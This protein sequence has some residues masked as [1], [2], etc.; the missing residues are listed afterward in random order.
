MKKVLLITGVVLLVVGVILFSVGY[1]VSATGSNNLTSDSGAPGFLS[2]PQILMANNSSIL[3]SGPGLYLLNESGISATT[4]YSSAVA[5][6]L[7][8]T[9]TMNAGLVTLQS[10]SVTTGGYYFV[11]YAKNTNVTPSLP[12]DVH[13]TVSPLGGANAALVLG[14]FVLGGL[15]L[16]IVG[17]ILTALG[18]MMKPKEAQPKTEEKPAE[19]QTPKAPEE[20]KNDTKI[21][22]EKKDES[23]SSSPPAD[24][25][26]KTEETKKPPT[27]K[28][29]S[30]SSANSKSKNKK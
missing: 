8:P 29:K 15:V 4:N 3:L 19:T 18:A 12:A 6:S 17:I 26:A 27:T 11:V 23:S 5:N 24:D 25:K 22:E 16:F 2:S 10:F 13:Y 7:K 9:S 1:A 20:Q 30:K 28:A 21:T 14:I